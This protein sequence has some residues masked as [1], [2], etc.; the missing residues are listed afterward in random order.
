MSRDR[1]LLAQVMQHTEEL[2]SSRSTCLGQAVQES[3][4]SRD[5]K[6][7]KVSGVELQ[8]YDRMSHI[9]QMETNVYSLAEEH[10]WH[11]SEFHLAELR[12][13]GLG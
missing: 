4:Q 11:L 3:Q 10:I 13:W 7:R 5:C 9:R 12:V 1:G 6:S 2:E 8:L